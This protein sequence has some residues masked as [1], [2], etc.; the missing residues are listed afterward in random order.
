MDT[1]NS[2]FELEQE[3]RRTLIQRVERESREML[4]ECGQWY[5]FLHA[6]TSNCF[7]HTLLRPSTLCN[8]GQSYDETFCSIG[9]DMTDDCSAAF[10]TD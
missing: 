9:I 5:R 2:L 6:P 3:E 8:A 1:T 4:P 10:Q 7:N